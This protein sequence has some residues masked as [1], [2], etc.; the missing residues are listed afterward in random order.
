MKYAVYPDTKPESIPKDADAIHL[1]RPVKAENLEKIINRLKL[2]NIFCSQSC[3]KRFSVKTKKIINEKNIEIKIAERKGRAIG[4]S[5][6]T[7]RK[8]IDLYRD[9]KTFREIEEQ[10]G[11]PKSTAH[12]LIKYSDR[13][14]IRQGKKVVYLE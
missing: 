10:T 13:S 6:E 14:K 3:V 5:L 2:K 9:D 12:Y 11:I 8:V 1:V 4:L 7:M